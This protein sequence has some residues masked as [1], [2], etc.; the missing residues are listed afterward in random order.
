MKNKKTLIAVVL[1]TLLAVP[2]VAYAATSYTKNIAVTYG[3]KVTRNGEPIEWIDSNGKQVDAFI[4]EDTAYVPL[5]TLA[6]QFGASTQYHYE[7]NT[8]DIIDDARLNAF[9]LGY[10][11]A[12]SG[13]E[14]PEYIEKYLSARGTM[15]NYSSAIS[16]QDGNYN[17]YYDYSYTPD[18]AFPLHLY[19][20]D[21]KVYLGKCVTDG[22]D[23]DSIWYSVDIAGD[24]SSKY[25]SNSIWN[26][27]GTYGGAYSQES[28]FSDY[29]TNPPMIVDNNGAFVAYLT[30]ND[31]ID[32]GWTIAELRQF[33]ENNGQ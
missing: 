25:G 26:E 10:E 22:Y 14:L 32:N 7:S 6:P 13:M 17:N 33:V 2:A 5:K 29:A 21:G 19:S 31:W 12:M 24:Y 30:T 27:Y 4:F 15:I 16:Q 11:A 20:N 18:Y 8:V 1:A 23:K 3:L 28:A 9:A